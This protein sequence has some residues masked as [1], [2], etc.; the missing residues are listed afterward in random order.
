MKNEKEKFQKRKLT[1]LD[2][3][4]KMNEREKEMKNQREKEAL[5]RN[6]KALEQANMKIDEKRQLLKENKNA[7]QL[8]YEEEMKER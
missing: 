1:E 4:K 2:T 3:F 8:G 5:G 6:N 7:Q